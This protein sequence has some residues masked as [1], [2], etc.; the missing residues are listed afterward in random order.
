MVWFSLPILTS[1][2]VF[3][4]KRDQQ[5]S[6]CAL[7]W[8]PFSMWNFAWHSRLLKIHPQIC[9]FHRMARSSSQVKVIALEFILTDESEIDRWQIGGRIYWDCFLISN[10]INCDLRQSM[11][12]PRRQWL[13]NP[14]MIGFL[15]G[16][17]WETALRRTWKVFYETNAKIFQVKL[18]SK[19]S[20]SA[21]S[22]RSLHCSCSTFVWRSSYRT[23]QS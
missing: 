16:D 12:K 4:H 21:Y 15:Y 18:V 3:N 8:Q 22:S 19:L 17:T 14:T 9:G 5:Q 13:N 10:M 2:R 7:P 1:S 20:S 6:I 11:T 23:P